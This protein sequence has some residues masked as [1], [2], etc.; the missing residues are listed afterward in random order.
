MSVRTG[1]IVV[2]MRTI[3]TVAKKG[4]IFSNY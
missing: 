2:V 1:G 4:G 3:P